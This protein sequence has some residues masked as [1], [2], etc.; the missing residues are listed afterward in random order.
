MISKVAL[1]FISGD[2]PQLGMIH[3]MRAIF[4][5]QNVLVLDYMRMARDLP[6][7]RLN[8]WFVSKCLS[9]KPEWLFLQAQ[10]AEKIAPWALAEMRRRLPRCVLSHW[11]GDVRECVSPYLASVCKE[12]HLTLLSST[13]Q[14]GMF[15]AAGAARA[16]YMQ[17][18][19]NWPERPEP[20]YDVPFRVPDVVFCGNH[21]GIGFSG[22]S[23]R[24]DAIRSLVSAGVDVG[25]VGRTWPDGIPV[26]GACSVADQSRIYKRAKVALSINNMN[27]IERY[28]SDRQL[29]AMGSGTPVVCR[30]V[31]GIEK[32]FIVGEHCLSYK[33]IDELVAAVRTLLSDEPMRRFIGRSGRAEVL[34]RHTWYSR[35]LSVLPIVEEM[36]TEL[37]RPGV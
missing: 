6:D 34:S 30:H 31:P 9:F 17:V 8:A 26:V 25:V 36:H 29:I 28:Y 33:T 27:D 2:E 3:D 1:A 16:E 12:T 4:G 14:L 35:F 10:E 5:E 19:Y 37:L 24:V 15:R 11:M 22:S 20:D 13:G 7:P 32:E 18:G 23:D 21:Y